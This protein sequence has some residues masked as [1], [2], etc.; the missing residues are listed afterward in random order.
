MESVLS[1]LFVSAFQPFRIR[2]WSHLGRSNEC[3]QKMNQRKRLCLNNFVNSMVISFTKPE[4]RTLRSHRINEKVMPPNK[5]KPESNTKWSEPISNLGFQFGSPRKSPPVI[6]SMFFELWAVLGATMKP[7]SAPRVPRSHRRQ[8]LIANGL[9]KHVCIIL[10]NCCWMFDK[11]FHGS[12][13]M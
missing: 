4:F 11:R 1:F 12:K 9:L 10:T 13:T 7:K 3:Y 6:L 8:C 2:L 5:N